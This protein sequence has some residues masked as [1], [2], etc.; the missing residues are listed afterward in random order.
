MV[1]IE[2]TPKAEEH[3]KQ[4]E[5]N[6]QERL[7]KK[8]REVQEN[9]SKLGVDPERYIKSLQGYNYHSLR[10]GDY[11]AIIKWK[12]QPNVFVVLAVGHRKTVYDRKL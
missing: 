2:F 5:P 4:L 11:R 12:K 3:V 8:F 9:T 7:E 1:S 6:V 10:I